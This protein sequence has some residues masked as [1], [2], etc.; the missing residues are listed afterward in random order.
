MT[1]REVKMCASTKLIIVVCN[2]II[3]TPKNAILILSSHDQPIME[4]NVSPLSYF[5]Y[6]SAFVLPS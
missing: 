3:D 6:V 2:F 1:S 4:Q 5:I